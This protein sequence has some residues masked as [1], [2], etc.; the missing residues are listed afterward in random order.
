MR[1]VF[2]ATKDGQRS[3]CQRPFVP[4]HLGECGREV[5]QRPPRAFECVADV[6]GS[7]LECCAGNLFGVSPC[8]CETDCD[9]KRPGANSDL[10]SCCD[11]AGP[12]ALIRGGE[13]AIAVVEI[14]L[15]I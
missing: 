7:L 13:V 1:L 9:L 5:G 12:G 11:V 6:A 14:D 10:G 8:V 15:Q 2:E 4:T 3:L